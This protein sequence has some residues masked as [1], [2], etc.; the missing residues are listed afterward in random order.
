MFPGYRQI[1]V[2][3]ACVFL[4]L[5]AAGQH[6]RHLGDDE[7]RQVAPPEADPE[8]PQPPDTPGDPGEGNPAADNPDEGSP[9][10]GEPTP[11]DPIDVTGRERLA[12]S[13]LVVQPQV[14]DDIEFTAIVN[15][16]RM[17]LDDVRCE[18]EAG[19]HGHAC[20]AALP[21]LAPGRHWLS[22]RA[23]VRSSGVEGLAS[24][25]LTL[26]MRVADSANPDLQTS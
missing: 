12:W 11:T 3:V 9:D 4:A 15:G 17:A 23:T 19:T 21:R 24:D 2:G 16:E 5:P 6:V 14:I 7:P 25:E 26:T 13:Q 10:S 8:E 22:L 18:A 1:L 20:S